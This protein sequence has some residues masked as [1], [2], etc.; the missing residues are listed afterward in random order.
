MK[1]NFESRLEAINWIAEYADD[2]AQ[3]EVFRE[4]LNFNHIY[5]GTFFI[6]LKKVDCEVVWLDQTS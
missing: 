1:Q 6:D 4:Q 3:F 2:E 5:T